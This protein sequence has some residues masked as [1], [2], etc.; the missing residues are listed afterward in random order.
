MRLRFWAG[1]MRD[2]RIKVARPRGTKFKGVG[3]IGE[4]RADRLPADLLTDAGRNNDATLA[5]LLEKTQIEGEVSRAHGRHGHDPDA[6]RTGCFSAL[7]VARQLIIGKGALNRFPDSP[8]DF[9]AGKKP[10][11]AAR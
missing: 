6:H 7:Q 2:D 3:G 9:G 1:Q 11:S 5:R 10:A 8:A 4:G